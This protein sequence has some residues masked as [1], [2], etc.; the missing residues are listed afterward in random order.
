V[1][2]N[3]QSGASLIE[4]L[5]SLTL[6]AF[7][8]LGLLGLQL[9]SMASQKDSIDRRTAAVL[10]SGF[11]ERITGNFAGFEA[12][13]YNNLILNPPGSTANAAPPAPAACATPTACT[14]AEIAARDWALFANEVRNRLPGGV[15]A[16]TTPAGLTRTEIVVGWIDT[17]RIAELNN[18]GAAVARDALCP[19]TTEF[20]DAAN[21]RYRC[22]IA[23]VHP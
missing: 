11:G 2:S 1:R 21:L 9:R 13:L 4:V 16:V 10:V 17:Q 20:N 6:V 18:A 5:I 8:M 19:N 22:Y 15:A 7:T 3:K 14:P 23:A 12:S